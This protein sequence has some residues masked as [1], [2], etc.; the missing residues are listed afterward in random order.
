M[1]KTL[2]IFSLRSTDDGLDVSEIATAYG[3]G[4]HRAAAGF[5]V[6]REHELARA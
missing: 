5:S 1:T 3:G 2:C 4:G 6:P